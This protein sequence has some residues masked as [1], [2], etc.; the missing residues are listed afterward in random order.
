MSRTERAGTK[1]A[2]LAIACVGAFAATAAPAAEPTASD[3]SATPAPASGD[4]DPILVNGK[5][6]KTELSSSKSTAPL[7][8]TPQTITVIN[9]KVLQ[10]QNLLT[11][12]DALSTLPGITFG[13][14]EGGGGYGDSINLRG[15]SANNDITIDGVRDSAQ[16][17]RT[18]TFN[19]QQIEVYNG[20]NS[21]FN[22]SGSVGGTINIVQKVPTAHDLTTISAGIGTDNYYRGTIDA[23]HM[24][25]DTVA[26]RI[27][28][29][30]HKND[31]PGRNV[32]DY[33]RW[34]IAPSITIGIN[35][36]TRLTFMYVHQHDNNVPQYGVPY[37]P[38]VGGKPA[39]IPYDAYYGY[40]NIDTQ[41]ST[42]DQGTMIF[43]HDFNDH[44][45]I[46]NLTRYERVAQRTVV[47]PPQGT[48]ALDGLCLSS[49]VTTANADGSCT[50]KVAAS[51]PNGAYT[52][53]VPEGYYLASGPRGNVR[54]T[55]NDLGYDQ[56]D[57]H[58][59]FKTGGIENNLVAGAAVTW[60]HFTLN[61][62]RELRN[63]NGSD[64][65]GTQGLPLIFIGDPST[66]IVG[67]AT[68]VYGNNVYN[69][70]VNFI[71]STFQTGQRNDYAAYLF[72][73]SKIG[74]YFEVNFGLR[75]ERNI[76]DA[77]ATTFNLATGQVG[78]AT[79]VTSQHAAN[80]LF[81]Y[82]GGLVFK[83]LPNINIYAAYGNS[84]TPSIST[85]NGSCTTGTV[86]T[87][88]FVNFCDVKPEKAKT[89]EVGIKA[90]LLNNKLE[91]TAAAFRNE[92]SNFK[93]SSNDP[94]LPPQ[95]VADGKSRV[96][97]IALGATGNLTK[98]WTVFA[99]YSYLKSKV[100]QGVSDRCVANPTAAD[101][102]PLIAAAPTAGG[103]LQQTPTHS[104]SLL[105]SDTWP[106]GLQLGYGLTYQGKFAIVT[107][108]SAL[109]N[110]HYPMSHAYLT[111][112][113][114]AA[115]EVFEGLAVQL[116]VQNLTNEHYYTSIRNNGWAEPGPLRSF[117]ASLNYSF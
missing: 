10:Q 85:V 81:S 96:D 29:V 52:V 110:G 45:S 47:D 57:L 98:A 38:Q 28:A 2:F 104:G 74:R 43:E 92:R 34:G 84:Q 25:T 65:Y 91:L 64:P 94:T 35:T 58:A 102:V 101:C 26:F 46:R 12:R 56:L 108:P 77:R 9:S 73:T 23:N 31:I 21:V 7:L 40:K 14:G 89:Y 79:F 86:G 82:R 66:T 53:T 93:V 20:A 61:T 97:G 111:H 83:P 71:P 48:F 37:F 62:G 8:D 107:N 42:L 24:I 67:P 78:Q 88:T 15:F 32:E 13:A 55:V 76:S 72:D 27:N 87:A 116:N 90:E 51:A 5:Q 36:P 60:E 115:Y 105:T 113:L 99:N 4:S 18:E 100:L 109:I 70:P 54:D 80:N 22:G 11:L 68:N 49:T 59:N 30:I 41:K 114:F 75:W 69:G 6:G 117:T 3:T 44:V 17:S 39:E 95:Q 63:A 1:P 103:P 16:Y 112:R 106:F 19:I 50:V 33:K